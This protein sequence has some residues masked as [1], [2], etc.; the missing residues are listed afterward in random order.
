MLFYDLIDKDHMNGVADHLS[1]H[2]GCD[3]V[4]SAFILLIFTLFFVMYL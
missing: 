2:A 4:V 1:H 3:T